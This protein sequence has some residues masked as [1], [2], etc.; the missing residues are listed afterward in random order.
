MKS[1]LLDQ[2][3]PNALES[4]AALLDALSVHGRV[5]PDIILRAEHFYDPRNAAIY[6]TMSDLDADFG[7]WDNAALIQQLQSH[8]LWNRDGFDAAYMA[9]ITGTCGNTALIPYH[10]QQITEA[11]QRRTVGEIAIDIFQKSRNGFTAD[12]LEQQIERIRAVAS[13]DGDIGRGR[14]VS[15]T[16]DTVAPQKIRWLWPNRIV[17]GKY[18]EIVGN[19]GDGK[20]VMVGDLAARVSSGK[21][22]PDSNVSMG[23]A[24]V[25]FISA[26]DDYADT[27][28]PRLEA[29]GA[30][31]SR[32]RVVDGVGGYDDDTGRR[33]LR[34]LS[35]DRDV[36]AIEEAIK[37]TPNCK[38][39]VLD[40]IT[41]YCGRIDS[42]KN[43]EV[44]AL[45]VPIVEMA[46]THGVAVVGIT[47]FN[48]NGNG[49]AVNRGMGSQAWI[50]AAR[51][52][53]AVVRDPERGTRLMLPI[54]CNLAR[55]VTGLSYRIDDRD[56]VPVVEWL[57]EAVTTTVDEVLA[58]GQSQ[59][60]T[61]PRKQDVKVWLGGKLANGPVA[62]NDILQDGE[63]AG[64]SEKLLRWAKKEIAVRSYA[65]GFGRDA[66]WFWKLSDE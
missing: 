46:S 7:G 63:A 44:R 17:V 49:K 32:I 2:P 66:V 27:I 52:V 47:H 13:G 23:P 18:N 28:R 4:E 45:L 5:D 20:T 60:R 64:F 39:L 43:A 54:K 48:K 37:T 31:L 3:P 42:H 9:G 33:M 24:G 30:D 35:L 16:L 58:E 55:D 57:P 62:A 26:E 14:V 50:A 21:P 56:G 41:A 22:C 53:W 61:S 12:A 25:V 10:A 29:A 51:M 6:S 59:R 34:S 38:M 11:W 40:P 36:P 1:E 65:E 19:P 15:R 8:K